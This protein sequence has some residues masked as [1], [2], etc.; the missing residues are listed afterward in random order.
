MQ[1][2][3][4]Q[5]SYWEGEGVTL[6]LTRREVVISCFMQNYAA[7]GNRQP[8]SRARPHLA[9]LVSRCAGNLMTS[10]SSY[11]AYQHIDSAVLFDCISGSGYRSVF[12]RAAPPSTLQLNRSKAHHECGLAQQGQS[13]AKY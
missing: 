7:P 13:L 3:K 6:T 5:L 12:V 10:H 4:M 2:I 1:R 11:S 9:T 8:T